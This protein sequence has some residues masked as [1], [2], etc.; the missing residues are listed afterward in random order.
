M[1][2]IVILGAGTAGTMLAN[3]LRRALPQ[4]QWNIAIVDQDNQHH[5]QPGYLFIPFGTYKPRSVVKSRKSFIPRGVRFFQDTITKVDREEKLVHLQSGKGLRYDYLIVT[6]GTRTRPDMVPGMAD[7]SLWYDK[8]FDFYTLEGS[9]R[10]AEALKNMRS[11]KLVVHISE[12]PIKCPVA[13]IEFALLADD[14]FFKRRLRDDIEITFVTPLDGPFTK[15]VASKHLGQL[16]KIRD[17]EVEGDFMVSHI[18]NEN[19]M[20]VS[21]D[22]REIPFDVLVTVPPNTGQQFIMDSGMGDDVGFVP[23]DHHT[24]QSLAD[25]NIFCIGD[26]AAVPTSKAGS[27]AHFQGDSF[28]PNFLN[29]IQGIPMSE[30][31]DGH[32]NCFIETGKG[33][34]MLL[35]FNYEQEP[36]PGVFPLPVVGP[37]KL[38]R[39]SRLNHLAKLAFYYVY[40]WLLI[41]GLPLPFP[42]DMSLVGKEIEVEDQLRTANPVVVPVQTRV[43]GAPEIQLQT[44]P[45]VSTAPKVRPGVRRRA[46]IQEPTGEV[47]PTGSATGTATIGG[48]EV[49]VNAEGFMTDPGQWDEDLAKALAA[50]IGIELS[51]EHWAALRFMRQDHAQVGVTPTLRRMQTVGGFHP[52]LLFKLFPK[53]PAK[54]MAYIAGLPKPVGC[55]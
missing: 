34:G 41:R 45:R 37:L 14:Y 1:S 18:D 13:P 33:K 20:L 6:T 10:L 35:D 27:V 36:V 54:K 5:Y 3:K 9:S 21:Y 19:Q 29:H 52:Q 48:R 46:P 12:M 40:W 25:P 24:L 43:T 26:A 7:G 17:I 42:K 15:P 2:N 11:G 50:L 49:A 44:T 4:G 39:M 23:V 31:F 38:L 22:D 51:E 53:K 28:V 55:V 8:V 30:T 47:T 32:S 16:M